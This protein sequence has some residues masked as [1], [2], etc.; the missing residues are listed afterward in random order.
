M[1]A[2]T[3]STQIGAE[4]VTRCALCER[5]IKARGLCATHYQRLRRTGD[6]T[7]VRRAGRPKSDRPVW[8]ATRLGGLHLDWSPRTASRY[9]N[10]WGLVESVG[11]DFRAIL[12][13][14]T[15]PNGTLNVSQIERA[16]HAAVLDYLTRTDG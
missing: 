4:P 16:A 7:T 14:A 13:A 3:D 1:T 8:Q 5:S 6:S 11:G 10:A 9:V 2:A 15:R 12:A